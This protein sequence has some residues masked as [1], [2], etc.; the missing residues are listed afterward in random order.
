MKKRSQA[1]TNEQTK[2]DPFEFLMSQHREVEALFKKIEDTGERAAK[3]RSALFSE[4]AYKIECHAQLEE[5]ILYPEGK[6]VDKDLTLE[7]YEEHGVVRDLIRKMT[8]TSPTDDVF[9]AQV[10]VLKELIEHHVKEEEEEYFPKFRKDFDE[11]TIAALGLKLA[12][13]AEV[14]EEKLSKKMAS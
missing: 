6:P 11:E 13:K 1:K 12:E 8:K 2:I 3:T 9:M 5:K 10:T 7:A 14:V 4:L